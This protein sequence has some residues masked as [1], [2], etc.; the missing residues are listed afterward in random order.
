MPNNGKKKHSCPSGQQ[1]CL[2]RVLDTI[3]KVSIEK[4]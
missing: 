3:K 4:T 1:R 2:A